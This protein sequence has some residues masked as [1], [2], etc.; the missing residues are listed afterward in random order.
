MACLDDFTTGFVVI[1]Y[2]QFAFVVEQTVE[3]F[4]FEYAVSETSRAFLFQDIEGMIDFSFT[5][6]AFADAFFEG[7]SLSE[8]ERSSGD[9]F[10]VLRFENDAILIVVGVGDLMFGKA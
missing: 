2:V 6:G 8:D 1:R 10:E 7:R 9:G 3:I 5:F 4:P